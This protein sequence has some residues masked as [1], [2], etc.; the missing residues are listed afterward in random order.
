MLK[1]HKFLFII[2][3]SISHSHSME[4]TELNDQC[5]NMNLESVLD[6]IK[7]NNIKDDN[8][9]ILNDGFLNKKRLLSEHDSSI[10]CDDLNLSMIV[11]VS[12]NSES[13]DSILEICN[14]IKLKTEYHNRKNTKSQKNG[15]NTNCKVMKLKKINTKKYKKQLVQDSLDIGLKE[16][17]IYNTI[18]N[19]IELEEN[20][21]EN[22]MELSRCNNNTNEKKTKLNKIKSKKNNNIPLMQIE[23][24]KLINNNIDKD[25]TKMND[26]TMI[27]N[28]FNKLSI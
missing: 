23:N 8:I 12:E 15:N 26:S 13:N 25:N 14:D 5:T 3:I 1:L 27:A 17:E 22:K 2:V 16:Q 4:H 19:C 28:C 10:D 11:N 21:E 7:E 9:Q 18:E 24:L 20:K 6:N